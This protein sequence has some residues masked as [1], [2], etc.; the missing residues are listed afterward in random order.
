M[1]KTINWSDGHNDYKKCTHIVNT[2]TNQH[3]FNTHLSDVETNQFESLT[4]IFNM[5]LSK[6]QT[7]KVEVLYSGGIDSE[8][9]LLS[10][11]RNKIPVEAT[12]LRIRVDDYIINSHDLYY[13]EKFCRANDVKH[14]VVDFNGSTFFENGDHI[15][16]LEPYLITEPHVATHLWLFEQAS[17]FPV[18]GGDHSWPWSSEPIL[19]PHRHEYSCYDRFLRDNNIH[20]IGNMINHSS[21]AN[22]L[23]IRTHL[24][25]YDGE[26]HRLKVGKLKQAMLADMG[27]HVDV[28]IR[29]HGWERV[30]PDMLDMG[31]LKN[32]LISRFGETTSSISWDQQIANAMSANPG[33][34]DRYR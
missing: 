8:L 4:D 34:N 1:I 3:T 32:D 7:K 28:R 21:E 33:S 2:E 5:H 9:T 13:S 25:I 6:R 18:I 16:F 22:Q 29:S 14:N 24:K 19:S 31:W 23:F 20:G 27:Y 10:C 26:L 15:R 17:G 30:Y 12:T 11:L